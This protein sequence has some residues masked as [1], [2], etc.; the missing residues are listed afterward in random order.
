MPFARRRRHAP[1]HMRHKSQVK[2]LGLMPYYT[3]R[4]PY[5]LAG[6]TEWHPTTSTGPFSVLTR[7]AFKT[8]KAARAWATKHL[9]R[10]DVGRRSVKP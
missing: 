8:A 9:G 10:T 4:I 6:A 1:R 3:V 7:G 5:T 2:A